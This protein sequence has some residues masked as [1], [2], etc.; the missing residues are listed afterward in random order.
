MNRKR[1]V[2]GIAV[3]LLLIVLGGGGWWWWTHHAR[4]NAADYLP[5]RTFL[6]VHIPD[7]NATRQSYVN[8]RLKA[9]LDAGEIKSMIQ[10]AKEAVTEKMPPENKGTSTTALEIWTLFERNLT[11]EAFLAITDVDFQNANKIGFIAGAKPAQGLKDMPPLVERIKQVTGAAVKNAKQGKA[12]HGGVDYEWVD[13]EG[14]SKLCVA[15]VGPW[16]IVTL[17][18]TALN[19]FIDRFNAKG[20]S[21]GSLAQSNSYKSVL[22]RM[23]AKRDMVAYVGILPVQ[24]QILKLLQS[25]PGQQS[26]A[27]MFKRVYNQ[28]QG[29]GWSAAFEDRRLHETFIGLMPKASRPDLGKTYEPCAYKTLA[30]TSPQT[31]IYTAQNFDF[32]KYWDYSVKI[33]SDGSVSTAQSMQQ[34][35]AWFTAQHLD[36]NKNLL[37]ALGSEYALIVDWPGDM[38]FPDLA[39]VFDVAKPDDL[40][41]TIDMLLQTLTPF[42]GMDPNGGALEDGK[43]GAYEFKTYRTK[44]MP[45]ISPTLVTRGDK[46]GIFL[47]QTAAKRMLTNTGATLAK[48]QAF[49]EVGGDKIDGTTGLAYINFGAFI[50]RAYATAK[51]YL[52]LAS[53]MSPDAQKWLGST[54]FPDTLSFTADLGSWLM[55][56][57][58]D[59]NSTVTETLSNTGNLPITAVALAAGGAAVINS[60]NRQAAARKATL[61]TPGSAPTAESVKAE[62]EELRAVIEAYAVAKDIP[63]GTAV[64]WTAISEYLVPDSPLQKNGGKDALGNDYV[65]GI[66]GQAPADVSPETKAKFPDRGDDFWKATTPLAQPSQ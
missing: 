25:Q 10:M 4:V 53:M 58:V 26:S 64:T 56:T 8:S 35:P 40:K 49:T 28:I 23:P 65:L 3:A 33:S 44:K 66:V 5:E 16:E 30:M 7:A 27:E 20:K 55:R 13:L 34:V 63:K 38:M 45:M 60:K 54:K 29:V 22:T 59:D 19:D 21:P 42:L 62:L 6:F 32:R 18:E 48:Q 14:K 1:I 43:A 15:A 9:F 31:F 41:P 11:G 51:P 37:D 17:G 46:F 61:A 2:S 24:D 47:T 57:R 39:I 12:N 52:G 50:D 36:F